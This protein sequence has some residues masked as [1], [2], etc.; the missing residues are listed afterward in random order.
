[1]SDT[2]REEAL[3]ENYSRLIEIRNI[4]RGEFFPFFNDKERL[5]EIEKLAENIL[6]KI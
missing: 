2:I 5:E 1:M 4:A 6:Q 3:K